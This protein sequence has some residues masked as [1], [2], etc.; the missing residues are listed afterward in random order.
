MDASGPD[1]TAVLVGGPSD[2]WL[3][4]VRSWQRHVVVPTLDALRTFGR[5][6]APPPADWPIVPE[7][8]YY[9]RTEGRDGAGNVVFRL[10]Q[11]ATRGG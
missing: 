5:P 8:T 10:E 9:R 1:E 11:E 7:N 2:G 3:V 4:P 6:G